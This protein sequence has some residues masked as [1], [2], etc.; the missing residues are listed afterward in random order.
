ML[1]KHIQSS[2]VALNSFYDP[3]LTYIFSFNSLYSPFWFC[4]P[5]LLN[6]SEFLNVTGFY[7]PL[8]HCICCFLCH[9]SSLCFHSLDHVFY[10]LSDLLKC[11]VLM[12]VCTEFPIMG[13]VLLLQAAITSM[14][15]FDYHWTVFVYWYLFH[16]EMW[17]SWRHACYYPYFLKADY[18]FRFIIDFNRKQKDF[19][20]NLIGINMFS[21]VL[22]VAP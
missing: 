12:W 2:W 1:S 7:R 15:C 21:L 22:L 4:A 9:K 10:I 17:D 3:G 13:K 5:A 20:R 8:Y 11:W 18:S 14:A 6:Y 16:H 19:N